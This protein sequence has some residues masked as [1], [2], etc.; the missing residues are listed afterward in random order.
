MN[1]VITGKYTN[2][3]VFAENVEPS[4]IEQITTMVNHP[5][6][7]NKIAIMPDTHAGKGSVIGFTMPVGERIIPNVIGVDISCG[8]LAADLGVQEIGIDLRALDEKIRERV[9]FGFKIHSKELADAHIFEWCYKKTIE[10]IGADE[11]KVLNSLGTLGGGNHFI[12]FGRS[13]KTGNIWVTIHTGSRNFGKRICDY[14]QKVAKKNLEDIRS[15]YFDARAS[16]ISNNTVDKTKIEEKFKELHKDMD[17]HWDAHVGLESLVEEDRDLYL[18]DM[19]VAG[20]YAYQNRV[21]ILQEIKK[22]IP[23]CDKKLLQCIQSI[24]NYIS[25]SDQIIRKGA[26]SSYEGEILIIPFNMRDGVLLCEGKGNPEWNYSAPHGAGRVLS[27]KKAKESIS[28]D[29]FKGQMKDVFSTSVCV[30][31]LDEAPDAYKD[32]KMIERLLSPTA[33]VID[34]LIPIMNLKAK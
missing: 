2:A 11:E 8:M 13:E 12:E 19:N 29:T 10:R 5:A 9:P 16:V 14:W 32:S 26:I 24:H 25:P 21:L 15:K 34:R 6:F 30:E 20:I 31:T 3:T 4:C 18:K 22:I 7:T 33:T 17:E 27:R 28:L 1:N 23:S